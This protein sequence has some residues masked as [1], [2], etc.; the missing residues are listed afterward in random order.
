MTETE[1]VSSVTNESYAPS[2]EQSR[3][4]SEAG[5]KKD[6]PGIVSYNFFQQI[7]LHLMLL[8]DSRLS[9]TFN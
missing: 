7:V 8:Y 9:T 4:L 1:A 2:A 6:T 3:E 5:H